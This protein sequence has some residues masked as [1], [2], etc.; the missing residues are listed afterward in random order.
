M[1][2]TKNSLALPLDHPAPLCSPGISPQMPSILIARKIL[3]C[4]LIFPVTSQ[5]MFDVLTQ[6]VQVLATEEGVKDASADVYRLHSRAPH[7]VRTH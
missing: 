1:V 6:G 4:F 3:S 2:S 7:P 5:V